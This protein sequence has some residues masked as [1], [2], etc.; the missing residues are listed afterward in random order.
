MPWRHGHAL[1]LC[2]DSMVSMGSRRECQSA[3]RG[4]GEIIYDVSQTVDN[5]RAEGT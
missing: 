3:A 4:G 5:N 2:R 1:S